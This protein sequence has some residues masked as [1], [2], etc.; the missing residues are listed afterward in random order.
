MQVLIGNASKYLWD[1]SHF[2][3]KNIGV[4][5]EWRDEMR[6]SDWE[7]RRD[8]ELQSGCKINE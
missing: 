4:M 5:D 1:A 6:G 3:K 7:K 8:G 2:L